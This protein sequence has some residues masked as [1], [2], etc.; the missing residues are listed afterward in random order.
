[1]S[2]QMIGYSIGG[3]CKRFLVAPPSMIWPANLV[4]AALFNTL[5]SQETLGSQT[6]SGI[7][8]QRFFTYVFVS[9]IF[10]STSVRFVWEN[11]LCLFILIGHCHRL[12]TLLSFH[13]SL[14]F[15]LDLL[16][17]SQQCRGQPA[18][19]CLS[20]PG[21]GCS[22]LRLGSDQLQRLSSS[23]P[24]VGR[25]Q[26]WFHRCLLLLVHHPHFLCESSLHRSRFPFLSNSSQYTNVWYTAYLPLVS[27]H[28]FDNTGAAYNVSKVINADTSFNIEA[29]K[30]Y[31]PIFISASFAISYGLSFASITATLTHTFLY[32]H[33]QISIQARRSLSE[34][35]DIHAR[36]MSMYKEVPD[37]WY[38]TIFGPW[39]NSNFRPCECINIFSKSPC[40]CLVS[41]PSR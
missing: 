5:H 21:H 29:Y 18:V 23:C 19:R 38:L 9:H 28:S 39:T 17:G 27:S 33:K 8:R 34:Q 36:L 4:T 20:R 14:E 3:I 37:W 30:A 6:R 32:Y 11:L 13:C 41:L 16:D 24:L 15:L 35:P 31:S 2:T 40:S 7:S 25:G 12:L 1:M 10:Y 22:H 26:H